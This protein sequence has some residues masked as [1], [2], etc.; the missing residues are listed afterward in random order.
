MLGAIIGDWVG[1]VHEF[2]APKHKNFPLVHP[3]C[4]ITDDSILTFAVADWIMH[5]GGLVSR[6]HDLV[7]R[8]P[9]SGWGHMFYHWAKDRRPSPYHSYGNGAGMRAS[10]C[11]WAFDSVDETLACAA[12]SARV[13]H[14]HPE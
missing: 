2:A 7:E 13:T 9:A 12:D 11:G 8:Y 3:D 6:F 14:D 4:R 10:P 5:G 1:S